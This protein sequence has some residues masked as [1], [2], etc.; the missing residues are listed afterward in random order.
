MD[1]DVVVDKEE[2]RGQDCTTPLKIKKIYSKTLKIWI[3]IFPNT[4]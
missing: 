1:D 2:G 3:S 4:R